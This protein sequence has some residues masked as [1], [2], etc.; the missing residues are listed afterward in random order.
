M[1]RDC[2][3]SSGERISHDKIHVRLITCAKK[4]RN[5][6]SETDSV[7]YVRGGWEG[8]TLSDAFWRRHMGG[9]ANVSHGADREAG[10]EGT[11]S[12]RIKENPENE[13]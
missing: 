9:P 11:K 12:I 7:R 5:G 6:T 4:P 2:Y 3:P 1:V 10:R 8:I 13:Y